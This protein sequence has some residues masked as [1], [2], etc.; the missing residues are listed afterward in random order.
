MAQDLAKQIESVTALRQTVVRGLLQLGI[1][2]QACIR[3]HQEE[4]GEGPDSASH[5]SCCE[6]SIWQGLNCFVAWST[7][8]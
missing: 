6:R 8:C 1:H 7:G 4:H 5:A 2:S 3:M